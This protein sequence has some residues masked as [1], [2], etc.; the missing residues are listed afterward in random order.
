[1]WNARDSAVDRDA[2][3]L[4]VEARRLR[5]IIRELVHDLES[6]YSG[7]LA[8]L[9]RAKAVLGWQDDKEG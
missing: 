5:E 1:M 8:S 9:D 3:R 4:A 6:E 2:F 7:Q